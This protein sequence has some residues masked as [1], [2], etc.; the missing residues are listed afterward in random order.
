MK[1]MFVRYCVFGLLIG[2]CA[3][4]AACGN[5]AEGFGRDVEKAGQSIQQSVN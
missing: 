4:V 2:A 5:T 3:V 1:K